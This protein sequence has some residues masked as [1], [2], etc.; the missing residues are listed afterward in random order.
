VLI[1]NRVMLYDGTPTF[2][3]WGKKSTTKRKKRKEN[4]IK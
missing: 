3:V 2:S 1:E 4:K